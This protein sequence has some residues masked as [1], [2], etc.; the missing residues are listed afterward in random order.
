MNSFESIFK[1]H[2][3]RLKAEFTLDIAT[4]VYDH[5][6]RFVFMVLSVLVCFLVAVID[7]APQQIPENT[8]CRKFCWSTVT[9]CIRGT[10]LQNCAQ[11]LEGK[12]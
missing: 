8:E 5:T 10:K 3:L 2:L 7:V 6:D 12:R 4:L 1:D 11:S 9:V